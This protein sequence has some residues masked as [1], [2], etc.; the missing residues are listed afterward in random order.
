MVYQTCFALRHLA[1]PQDL[2]LKRRCVLDSFI[3]TI[4]RH[5]SSLNNFTPQPRI[6]R[7]FSIIYYTALFS[8]ETDVS[9]PSTTHCCITC[10]SDWRW[11]T[12]CPAGVEPALEWLS[13][14]ELHIGRVR[15]YCLS[16][17]LVCSSVTVYYLGIRYDWGTCLNT[18]ISLL[19]SR[20]ASELSPTI[21]LWGLGC[22]PRQYRCR[23][24]TG[25]SMIYIPH[26]VLDRNCALGVLRFCTITP[27]Q[28]LY[29]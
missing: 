20:C 1:Q 16:L 14:K 24:C 22:H 11:T 8:S 15:D 2:V 18:V 5:R 19:R 10:L 3:G 17:A 29:T 26:C 4:N 27:V 23:P 6:F 13:K 21:C 7:V 12:K 25:P 28:S 9:R